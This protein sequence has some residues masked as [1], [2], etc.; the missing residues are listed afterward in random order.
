[1][2]VLLMMCDLVE[3]MLLQW[4]WVAGEESQG[5]QNSWEMA[6]AMCYSEED[7]RYSEFILPI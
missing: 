3:I 2:Q 6:Q 1:M 4:C 7:K 5:E